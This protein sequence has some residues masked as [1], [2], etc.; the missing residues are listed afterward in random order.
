MI[1]TIHLTDTELLACSEIV[2]GYRRATGR[3][4]GMDIVNDLQA[5][6]IMSV[7]DVSHT[8]AQANAGMR[9]QGQAVRTA[10]KAFGI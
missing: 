9:E 4:I 2:E 6:L 5:A 7:P 10:R 8:Y 1:R 3:S